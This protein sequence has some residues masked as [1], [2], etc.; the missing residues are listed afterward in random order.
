M[1]VHIVI[2]LDFFKF[3]FNFCVAVKQHKGCLSYFTIHKEVRVISLSLS[4]EFA[5]L[6]LHYVDENNPSVLSSSLSPMKL[7]H[8]YDVDKKSNYKTKYFY[9]TCIKKI[10]NTCI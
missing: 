7:K 8:C 6:D 5:E 1:Q 10:I 4:T 9:T 2:K 3:K